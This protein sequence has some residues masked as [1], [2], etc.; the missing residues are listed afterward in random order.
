MGYGRQ[1]HR[2]GFMQ[3][4]AA[5]FASI[6]GDYE[7]IATTTVGAGG[8]TPITFSSIPQT[9]KHLQI[10]I[11]TRTT[12]TSGVNWIF[13]TRF[14]G[15]TGSNYTYHG[16]RGDGTSA[17]SYAGTSQTSTLTVNSGDDANSLLGWGVGVVDILDYANTNKHK[18]IRTLSGFEENGSGMVDLISGVWMSTSAITSIS[19][20]A[21]TG[22]FREYSSF[23]LYGIKG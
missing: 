15:D 9:Y 18:T 10:R 14:N 13:P 8:T 17:V 19:I 4:L 2:L 11:L 6:A 12:N 16:L 5:P 1:R 3:I 7:S 20:A 23:A 21:G 22:N